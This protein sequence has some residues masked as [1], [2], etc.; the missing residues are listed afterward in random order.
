MTD[1]RNIDYA[2]RY[3][4]END[5]INTHASFTEQAVTRGEMANVD[6][7]ASVY[8]D[9]I[10]TSDFL[11]GHTSAKFGDA[12]AVQDNY[13]RKDVELFYE[14]NKMIPN[15]NVNDKNGAQSNAGKVM[16]YGIK[17]QL[18]PLMDKLRLGTAIA[19]AKAFGG[20]N[21]VSY[22]Q[23]NV[24][25]GIDTMLSV[26][27]DQ[28]SDLNDQWVFIANNVKPYLDKNLF[29]DY[30]P[31]TNDKIVQTGRI[32]SLFGAKCVFVPQWYLTVLGQT[33]DAPYAKATFTPDETIKA[34]VWD[35]TVLKDVRKLHSTFLLTGKDAITAG[36]DGP[37][38]RGLFRPGAW[39]F[40]A[41][42]AKKGA[43]ILQDTSATT[44]TT[45]V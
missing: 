16:G 26:L 5:Q 9:T 36:Y 17:E 15:V 41:N 29:T 38:I 7:V 30:T 42:G 8:F 25:F 12:S 6:G 19:G 43:A 24:A 10:D 4:K 20:A 31:T 2:T 37:V 34:V 23:S 44:T 27:A 28:L 13:N 3:S 11:Q 18:V 39:L 1:D 32:K 22:D 40:D 45:T 14:F 33:G 35:K 21:I